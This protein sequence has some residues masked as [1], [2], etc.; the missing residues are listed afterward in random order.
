MS[1]VRRIP[2]DGCMNFR[3]LGGYASA[4]G[5]VTRWGVL[6][7]A[8][9]LHRLS[10]ADVEVVAGRLGVRT[11]VDLRADDERERVGVLD[12]AHGI[13]EHHVSTVDGSLHAM[14]PPDTVFED[15]TFAQL[16]EN[17]IRSGGPRY[18]AAI[19]LVA[20]ADRWPTAFFCMAGKDRTGCLAAMVLG[21]VGVSP[22]DIVADYAATAPAAEAIRERALAEMPEMEE[23]WARLPDDI[24]T[25]PTSAM[26]ELLDIID[27]NWGGLEGYATAHGVQPDTINRLRQNFLT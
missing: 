15:L 23:V 8:D 10:V 4:L 24:I 2:L 1:P 3:D 27:H 25:A 21:L 16:Y 13:E 19:E 12:P 11:A 5:G 6:F 14:R 20:D 9:S 22:Q 26:T 7:R 18:A 17:M